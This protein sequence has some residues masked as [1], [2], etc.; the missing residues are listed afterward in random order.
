MQSWRQVVEAAA[1]EAID[2]R[3]ATSSSGLGD[4]S[5]ADI[6]EDVLPVAHAAVPVG[7]RKELFARIKAMISGPS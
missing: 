7:I 6:I 4:V 2:R 5:A 3:V 1:S